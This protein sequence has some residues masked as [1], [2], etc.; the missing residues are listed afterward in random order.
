MF[1]IE[2]SSDLYEISK[3]MKNTT[4]PLQ[5]SKRRM[6]FWEKIYIAKEAIENQLRERY[7]NKST[8]RNL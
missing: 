7:E 5:L 6:L 1:K 8:L 4:S 2:I 3:K